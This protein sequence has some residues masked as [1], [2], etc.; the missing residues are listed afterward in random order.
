MHRPR[1]VGGGNVERI[2]IIPFALDFRPGGDRKAQVRENLGEFVHHLADRMD[3]A[4]R[5]GRSGQGHVQ[6]FGGEAGVEHGGFERGFARGEGGGNRFA[7]AVDQRAHLLTL[8]S[9]HLP[10]QFQVPRNFT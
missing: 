8:L 9:R 7:G 1:R 10:Q 2:E 4:T 5:R 3:T 6:P